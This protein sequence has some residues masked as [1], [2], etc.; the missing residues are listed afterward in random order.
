MVELSVVSNSADLTSTIAIAAECYNVGKYAECFQLCSWLYRVSEDK[1]VL[2]KALQLKGKAL[3]H[4][5]VAEKGSLR[6]KYVSKMALY[7]CYNKAREAINLLGLTI[8][9]GTDTDAERLL[10]Q[11]HFTYIRETRNPDLIRC[12][13]CHKK[14]KLRASHVW[15]KSV[16]EHFLKCIQA[17]QRQAFSVPWKEYGTLQS[18]KQLTF[19]MLCGE[20]EQLLNRSC[21]IKFKS[22]FFNKLYDPDNYS[23]T[24]ESQSIEYGEYLYRF[25]L[26]IIFRALPLNSVDLSEKGNAD[27]IYNLFSVCRKLLLSDNIYNFPNKPSI[28]LLIA[29]TSLPKGVPTV[30]MIHRILRSIGLISLS[31][32]S[33]HDCTVYHGKA[34]F[35]LAGIGVLNLVVSLDPHAPLLLPPTNIIKAEGGVFTVPENLKRFHAMPL[36]LW[37]ELE[38]LATTYAKKVFHLPQKL[39]AT[40]E[41]AKAELTELQS[42]LKST[43]P[44]EHE[45]LVDYLPVN[46]SVNKPLD[47]GGTFSL[48]VGHQVL[49]HT[50]EENDKGWEASIF[51]V[52]DSS[53]HQYNGSTAPC[54]QP[55]TVLMLRRQGVVVCIAYF[56]S[57]SEA[58]T[59]SCLVS[60]ESNSVLPTIEKMYETREIADALLPKLLQ[61]KGFPS[62]EAL[63]FWLEKG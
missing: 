56:I 57:N 23:K 61:M 26:S 54:D 63:L 40:Q 21:E 2:K 38:R 51:L 10:D 19:P 1:E 17:P 9:S 46:I 36:G 43:K 11:V 32:V 16:L 34:T 8:D 35:L 20:C 27:D 58:V 42:M 24:S 29:P 25:C 60:S 50:H 37:K 44:E 4:V 14:G 6:S 45:T 52:A 53:S 22:E 30:P 5:F 28:A 33:L 55:Y 62:M 3:Y 41:W 39:L 59:S 31:S 48:P 12:L 7:S 15:P 18:A 47:H 13:L 49:L